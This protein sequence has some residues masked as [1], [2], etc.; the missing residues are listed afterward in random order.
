MSYDQGK[1]M[2]L[3]ELMNSIEIR[4]DWTL[5]HNYQLIA[6]IKQGADV[7]AKDKRGCNALIHSVISGHFD[8]VKV[9]IAIGADA[10]AKDRVGR[11]ALTEAVHWHSFGSVLGYS[12]VTSLIQSE[13]AKREKSLIQDYLETLEREVDLTMPCNGGLLEE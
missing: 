9:L 1:T 2:E 6:L 10:N 8:C 7:N 4:E 12:S 11:S 13:I 5:D 3:V